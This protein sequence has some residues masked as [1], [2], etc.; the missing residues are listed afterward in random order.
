MNSALIEFPGTLVPYAIAS[1]APSGRVVVAVCA[2]AR[3]R[4]KSSICA[5]TSE[6]EAL[7]D[8]DPAC[9]RLMMVPGI[10]PII[11]SARWSSRSA[12]A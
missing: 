11:S 5:V 7:A 12:I 2:L 10:G 4:K 3:Q 1:A 9:E 6:I 8:R